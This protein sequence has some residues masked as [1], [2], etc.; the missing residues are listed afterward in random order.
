[1]K[2]FIKKN[3]ERLVEMY[4][5]NEDGF[6][7]DVDELLLILAKG[8][9]ID[10]SCCCESGLLSV[11]EIINEDEINKRIFNATNPYGKIK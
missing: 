11:K 2:A 4:A 5:T 9:A 6:A 8:N 1:M 3:K 7:D 10:K